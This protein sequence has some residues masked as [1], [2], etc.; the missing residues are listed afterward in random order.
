M[1][2]EEFGTLQKTNLNETV[3]RQ[4]VGE[5]RQY[6]KE[7]ETISKIFPPPPSTHKI[8]CSIHTIHIKINNQKLQEKANH[9]RSLNIN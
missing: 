7:L 6:W 1:N 9:F 3:W 2:A 4:P 8:F 5:G